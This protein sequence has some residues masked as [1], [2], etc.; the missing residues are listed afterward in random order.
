MEH[1]EGENAFGRY[2]DIQVKA[3]QKQEKGYEAYIR[4]CEFL[5]VV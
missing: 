3:L 4:Q 2:K 1:Y 5:A